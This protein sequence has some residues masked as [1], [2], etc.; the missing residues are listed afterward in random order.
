VPADCRVR[1]GDQLEGAVG[2]LLEKAAEHTGEAPTIRVEPRRTDD[3]VV[4]TIGDD[5]P[6]IPA[7]ERPVIEREVDIDQLEHSSGLGLWYVRWVLDAYGGEL[8]FDTDGDG[9]T[10]TLTL[11]TA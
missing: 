9:T 8:A 10:V 4:L 6:G 5:G 3:G 7:A 1:S 11:P 2:E